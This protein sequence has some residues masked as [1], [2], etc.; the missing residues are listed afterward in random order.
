MLRMFN[1]SHGEEF[2]SV[3][4]MESLLKQILPL[5]SCPFTVHPCESSTLIFPAATCWVQEGRG[6]VSPGCLFPNLSKHSF[7]SLSNSQH[8]HLSGPLLDSPR[9]C[10]APLK[11]KGDAAKLGTASQE[12]SSEC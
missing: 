2:S 10:S 12:C 3:I 11:L 1:F 5:V 6:E 8:P 9:L 4:Q 7:F